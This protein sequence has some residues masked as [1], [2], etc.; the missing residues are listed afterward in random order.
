MTRRKSL[1]KETFKATFEGKQTRIHF[2]LTPNSK[3]PIVEL[4]KLTPNPQLIRF[5]KIQVNEHTL[6]A[7]AFS[8][9]KKIAFIRIN[10]EYIIIDKHTIRTLM[11][12]ILKMAKFLGIMKRRAKKKPKNKNT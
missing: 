1:R 7:Y 6:K 12:T 9:N 3:E 4:E 2:T 10:G 11:G 8:N 5:G